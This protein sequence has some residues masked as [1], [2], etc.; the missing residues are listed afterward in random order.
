[1]C[2]YSYSTSIHIR[3][4]GLTQII[5]Q[6]W[7]LLA[8]SFMWCMLGTQTPCLLCWAVNLGLSQW[9]C[10][11]SEQVSH[12]NSQV[13]LPDVEVGV[14]C[15]ISVTDYWTLFIF[16]RLNL[17]RYVM[18]ILAQFFLNAFYY[19]RIVPCPLFIRTVQHVTLLTFLVLRTLVLWDVTLCHWLSGSCCCRR[20]SQCITLKC[21]E[22]LTQWHSATSQVTGTTSYGTVK[23]SKFAVVCVVYRVFLVTV[24][25]RGLWY[26]CLPV[27]NQ[28][29][30]YLWE[31]CYRIKC[32]LFTC[33]LKAVWGKIS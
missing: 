33:T 32:K 5:K 8:S 3:L 24:I 2:Y 15:A 16:L 6:D 29:D 30:L 27:V 23:S 10:E 28:C 14:W 31:V 26:I 13:P 20:W 11:L 1:M 19:K 7:V 4:C 9:V 25:S 22:P 17:Y 12:V 21:W 18:H